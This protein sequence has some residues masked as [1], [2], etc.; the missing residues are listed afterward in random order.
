MGNGSYGSDQAGRR[1]ERRAV[2]GELF[3]PAGSCFSSFSGVIP[4]DRRESG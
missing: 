1:A 3:Q 2:G 4:S